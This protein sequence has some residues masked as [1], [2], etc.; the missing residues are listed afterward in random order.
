MSEL[1]PSEKGNV[2]ET[3]VHAIEA[4]IQRSFPGYSESAFRIEG[5]ENHPCGAG[6]HPGAEIREPC[7]SG[8]CRA[9]FVRCFCHVKLAVAAGQSL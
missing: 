6:V 2:L 3:A 8:T 7:G 4:A 9:Y 1:T 5:E